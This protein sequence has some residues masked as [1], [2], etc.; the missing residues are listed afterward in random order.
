MKNQ[1]RGW[2]VIIAILGL[3]VIEVVALLKGINGQLMALIVA[4]IAGLAGYNIKN[5]LK[6][7]TK[8]G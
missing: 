2:V 7:G 8:N 3:S 6:G 5:I 4:V 1:I